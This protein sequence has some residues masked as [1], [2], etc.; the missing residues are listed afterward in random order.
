MPTPHPLP[1][2]WAVNVHVVANLAILTLL[3]G[4]G[5]NREIGYH[6]L[7]PPGTTERTVQALDEITDPELRA[8]AQKLID[9][10][11]QRTAQAQAQADAFGAAVPDQQHLFDRLRSELPD[12]PIDLGI[13]NETLTITL[14]VAAAGPHAGALLTLIARW[15]GTTSPTGL[16]YGVTQ[17]LADDGTLTVTFDQPHAE[18]FLTWYRDQP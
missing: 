5:A 9:S 17:D 15:P 2:R 16:A 8:S 4:D 12:S 6:P 18:K 1:A 7:T 10:F 14:K 11:Y 13:D 3:D